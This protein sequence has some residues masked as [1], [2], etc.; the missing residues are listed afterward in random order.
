MFRGAQELTLDAKGR[1]MVP[2]RVRALFQASSSPDPMVLTIDITDPCI[3]AYPLQAWEPI[4]QKLLSLPTLDAQARRIQR[5]LLGH[6][7]EVN[8]DAQGRILIPDTLCEF[9][10]L[11]KS[12]VWV[13]L[14][15][16]FE[17]WDA[18]QWHKHRDAWIKDGVDEKHLSDELKGIS[19]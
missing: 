18:A 8:L 14:G 15:H 4:E 5:L 1:M 12:V 11:K 9:A 10:G 2:A 13:G 17:L 6:A 7:C 3:L 16:K 19:L